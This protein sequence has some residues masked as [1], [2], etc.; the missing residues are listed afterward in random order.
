[1]F[2]CVV[3]ILIAKP[4]TDESADPLVPFLALGMAFGFA[5]S[6]MLV[7]L[8]S[9]FDVALGRTTALAEE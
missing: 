6:A 4:G 3:N 7:P 1:M 8:L 5:I 9:E 2:Y